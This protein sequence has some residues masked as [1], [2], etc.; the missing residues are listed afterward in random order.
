MKS[1]GSVSQIISGVVTFRKSI[2][3]RME[4]LEQGAV[5]TIERKN[6]AK[7]QKNTD[8]YHPFWTTAPKL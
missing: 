8:M 6:G 2:P 5:S 3:G 1:D 7:I 4:A